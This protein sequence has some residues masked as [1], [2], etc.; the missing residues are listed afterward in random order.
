M[1]QSLRWRLLLFGAVAVAA[2][3]ALSAGGLTLLFERHV[4]RVA[5]AD[6]D[7]RALSVAAMVEP[8]AAGTPVFR[9][10][11][12]D[13][14]YDRPFSGHYWQAD[15]SGTLWR[16][17]SLWDYRFPESAGPAEPGTRRVLSLPGPQGEELLALEQWLTVGQGAE[18][19]P[20]RIVVATR[21]DELDLARRSFLSDLLPYLAVL[22][23]LILGASWMQITLGLR[24]LGEVSRRVA[25]LR[26]GG[27]P[28]IGQDLPQEVMPLGAEIDQLLDA[29]D[30]ELARA[31]HRAGDL[32]HGFKTP[33]QALLGDVAQLR[34]RGDTGLADSI[35]ATA[36]TMR[37]V[38]DR[39]LARLRIQSGHHGA[40]AD[41]AIVI[42]R[43]VAVLRRT[44]RGDSVRWQIDTDPG[45]LA[46]IEPQDLTEAVGG[47]AENA[48]RHATTEVALA[49]R[50]QGAWIE[51]TVRD[52]GPGVPEQD[53]SR[54][55]QR[56]V[57][58]DLSEGGQGIG[59]SIVAEIAEAAG[60]TLTLRNADPGLEAGLRIRAHTG[61]AAA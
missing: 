59:L 1:R 19:R 6:L 44:P 47:L 28:R 45:L 57:R 50:R 30:A 16:S 25:A 10:R 12:A 23:T 54:L 21:R 41:P 48:L 34:A 52:D 11:A 46:R 7:A 29:R 4:Q 17:R 9:P 22:G 18:S 38:V 15:L 32:A 33:L 20:L 36:L 31:R 58:L 13:P 3:L 26:S 51:V 61:H 14:L 5:V 27:R 37:R 24:P 2:A 56:G 43:V 42:D 53:L 55:V 35:E 8:D 40:E 39:E 49:A 60:G